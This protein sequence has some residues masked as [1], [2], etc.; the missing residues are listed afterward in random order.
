ME[1]AVKLTLQIVS[2]LVLVLFGVKTGFDLKYP[3]Q[4]LWLTS[5]SSL[6]VK[7]VS[8]NTNQKAD[9]DSRFVSVPPE[10]AAPKDHPP[11]RIIAGA[12]VY[13]IHYTTQAY[14]SR[15][16]CGAFTNNSM[17]EIW[18]NGTDEPRYQRKILMHELLH[19]AKWISKSM[20]VVSEPYG[21]NAN[22]DFIEPASPELL[23]I[24]QANPR[25]IAWLEMR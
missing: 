5:S 24:I 3:V 6:I 18:L 20:T 22:H 11:L 10:I 25:L 16:D 8:G 13:T 4:G 12:D 7:G 2:L 23:S 1:E 21:F 14:L 19:V 15:N 17:H 9:T